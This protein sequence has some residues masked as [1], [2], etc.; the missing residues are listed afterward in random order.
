MPSKVYGDGCFD[1][2]VKVDK[3]L[4]EEQIEWLSG[5]EC[6]DDAAR[7]AADGILGMLGRMLD[8]C[9]GRQDIHEK[10]VEL[11]L[12]DDGTALLHDPGAPTPFIVAHGYDARSKEW[13]RGSYHAEVLYAAADALRSAGISTVGYATRML[14]A[15]P[16]VLEDGVCVWQREDLAAQLADQGMPCDEAAVDELDRTM[17]GMGDWRDYAAQIGDE[18][19]VEAIWDLK[20]E[21]E[22]EAAKGEG[23]E[24]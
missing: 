10:V 8:A 5:V 7:D 22:R 23:G 21:R 19:I 1:V 13:E 2:Q 17:R 20:R 6:P 24:R 15:D 16:D 3:G 12:L 9:D 4:L 18:T 14:N 11:V